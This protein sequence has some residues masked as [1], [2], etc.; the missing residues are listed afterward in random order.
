MY[1]QLLHY[2]Q[3]EQTNSAAELN[4]QQFCCKMEGKTPGKAVKVARAP[5]ARFASGFTFYHL[6]KHKT[7]LYRFMQ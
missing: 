4:L 1:N 7:V 2:S 6:S 5:D 3:N